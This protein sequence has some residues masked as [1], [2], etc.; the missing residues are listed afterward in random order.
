[1]GYSTSL[2]GKWHLGFLPDYSPLKSGYDRFFGI[3]SG[4]R[5]TISI[6]VLMRHVAAGRRA[7]CMSRRYRS[8]AMA[9][10]PT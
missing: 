10:W 8:S 6:M 5:P 4:A 2:V 1:V 3:F 9:I 7:S